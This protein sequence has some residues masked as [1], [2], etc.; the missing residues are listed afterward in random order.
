MKT[1]VLIALVAFAAHAENF[2]YDKLK[3]QAGHGTAPTS[4][5]KTLDVPFKEGSVQKLAVLPS[6]ANAEQ[7][8]KFREQLVESGKWI[9]TFHTTVGH[10][11]TYSKVDLVDVK[12]DKEKG[13]VTSLTY[14]V[15]SD[16]GLIYIK[17]PVVE[18]SR[19]DSMNDKTKYPV[20]ESTISDRP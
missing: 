7:T 15:H 8:K 4:A 2:R 14:A 18:K 13:N 11:A 3:P 19:G 6:G 10:F 16:K 9:A 17:G 5:E 20:F 1:L 12:T